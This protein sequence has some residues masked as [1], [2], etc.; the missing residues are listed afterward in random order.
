MFRRHRHQLARFDRRLLWRFLECLEVGRSNSISALLFPSSSFQAGLARVRES[1][2]SGCGSAAR[3][4]G[5]PDFNAPLDAGEQNVVWTGTVEYLFI[6]CDGNYWGFKSIS[7][8]N[9]WAAAEG[10]I[11]E[12]R[13]ECKR[14][15]ETKSWIK[16]RE[17]KIINTFVEDFTEMQPKRAIIYRPRLNVAACQPFCSEPSDWRNCISV[18]RGSWQPEVISNPSSIPPCVKASSLTDC[19][20][21]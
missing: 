5:R 17:P 18:R 1:K 14:K 21:C 8:M 9:C 15:K 3:S 19:F 13:T 4:K 12:K 7:G 16:K 10:V 2:T 11:E 6:K 20:C